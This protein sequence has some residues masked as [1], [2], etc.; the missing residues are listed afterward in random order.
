[1]MVLSLITPDA[2]DAAERRAQA[3]ALYEQVK[4]WPHWEEVYLNCV[5]ES[6]M[7]YEAFAQAVRAGDRSR[8]AFDKAMQASQMTREQFARYLPA[9][10]QFAT[11]C[12]VYPDIGMLSDGADQVWHAFL[13]V[14][15]RYTQ[16]CLEVIGQMIDHLPCSLYELYGVTPPQ[17]GSNCVSSCLPSTCKGGGGGGGCTSSDRSTIDPENIARGI[18]ASRAAFI[19]AYEE[20]F[21]VPPDP[22]IWNQLAR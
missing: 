14:T 2:P 9:F 22:A 7:S 18:R 21:E 20:V 8:Q 17:A 4:A 12:A 11:L 13:L 19:Q 3:R 10:Q 16:F 5:K 15:D 6:P 1:M